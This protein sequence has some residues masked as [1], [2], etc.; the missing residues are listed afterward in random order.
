MIECKYMKLTGKRVVNRK[1]CEKCAEEFNFPHY[2]CCLDICGEANSCKY[3]KRY[4]SKGNER[5][6][7]NEEVSN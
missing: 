7:K 3:C 6:K 2:W 5:I 1:D 4:G